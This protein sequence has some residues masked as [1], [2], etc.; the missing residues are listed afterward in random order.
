MNDS[1]AR[2]VYQAADD[3]WQVALVA[4]YGS[5]AAGDARYDQRGYATAELASLKDARA[6][7]MYD[8]ESKKGI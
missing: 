4:A 6:R 7:A 1:L 3:A 5:A 8:F 2:R